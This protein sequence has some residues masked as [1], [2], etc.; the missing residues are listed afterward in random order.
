MAPQKSSTAGVARAPAVPPTAAAAAAAGFSDA[1][2]PPATSSQQS[3]ASRRQRAGSGPE[4]A[5]DGGAAGGWLRAWRKPRPGVLRAYHQDTC[6]AA[7]CPAA[8]AAAALLT[9]APVP[10]R[11][12]ARPCC[13]PAAAQPC[14]ARQLHWPPGPRPTS[15]PV[16]APHRPTAPPHTHTK[17]HT[18]T[19]AFTACDAD[20]LA[21]HILC[22]QRGQV[23]IARLKRVVVGPGPISK[24]RVHCQQGRGGGAVR[25]SRKGAESGLQ[26]PCARQCEGGGA[27]WGLGAAGKA[28]TA[29]GRVTGSTPRGGGESRRGEEGRG[30]APASQRAAC[31][32]ATPA[33]SSHHPFPQPVNLLPAA[34]CRAAAVLRTTRHTTKQQQ[35]A[36]GA[37]LG[38]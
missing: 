1:S 7:A 14:N 15:R 34:A 35:T 32:T 33:P 25:R 4:Q 6:H 17:P 22:K 30:A 28:A 5:A 18:S 20:V 3:P 19:H 36:P 2:R 31:M 24:H 13:M 37:H 12:Q 27:A 26:A 29:P 23:C 10:G 38:R 21:V 8:A 9:A 16:H 11:W